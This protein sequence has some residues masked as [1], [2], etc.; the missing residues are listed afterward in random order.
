MDTLNLKLIK[1]VVRSVLEN[2]HG[3]D[4]TLQGLGML[5]CHPW[6]TT[7]YRLNI[8][9]RDFMRVNVSET[10]DHPWHFT[11]WVVAGRMF[12]TRFRECSPLNSG[13]LP[14]YS[15]TV[16]C[17]VDYGDGKTEAVFLLQRPPENY[18]PG[19]CYMQHADEIHSTS[20]DDGT[21]TINHRERVK[22]QA[23]RIFWPIDREWIDA[24]PREA[25]RAEII[26]GCQIG[27]VRL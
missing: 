11:S 19:M 24:G 7:D 14:Y 9:H 22:G 15:R 1:T 8:W 3:Y 13:A 27:L 17:G 10:H 4:W 18:Y 12:N 23:A 6:G 20:F 2:P 5:R 25:S 16:N 26:H 21:I